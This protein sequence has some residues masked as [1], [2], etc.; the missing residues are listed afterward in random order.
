M[1]K[2][3]SYKS[4]AV[5]TTRTSIAPEGI[6]RLRVTDF[7]EKLGGS[8]YPYWA[9]TCIIDEGSDWDEAMIWH[10]VSLSPQARFKMDEW[11]DSFG[12]PEGQNKHGEEFLGLNFR[13]KLVHDTYEGRKKLSIDSS[14]PDDTKAG[15]KRKPKAK[16]ED[17]APFEMNGVTASEDE[18]VRTDKG[19]PDDAVPSTPKGKK[20]PF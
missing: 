8:G 14:L 3:P 18:D 17:T 6:H 11:L 10:N 9:F 1:A 13:A 5:D 4:T 16:K 12:I 15:R 19:L 20:R 7:E 2:K